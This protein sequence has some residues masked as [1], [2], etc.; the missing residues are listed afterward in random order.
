MAQTSKKNAPMNLRYDPYQVFRSSKTPA[1]LYARQKW[2][3]EGETP[4]WKSDYQNMVNGLLADQMPDGSWQHGSVE[5]IRHLF[6][7]HL[8]VRS[9][10]VQIEAGLNWLLNKIELRREKIHVN[11]EDFAAVADLKGLPFI[12]SRPDMLLTGAG[13]FLA[14][15]FGRENDPTVLSSYQWLS[16]QGVK[17]NGHWFDRASFHNIFRAMVVHPVFAKDRATGL[18]VEHLA[19]FQAKRGDWGKELPFY[20]TLNAL[21]HLNFSQAQPQ[22]EKAFERLFETQN[23]DGSWGRI[24]PEW[25]TFLAI[26][27]LKNKELI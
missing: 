23:S 1:G 2:I 20:Q 11:D 18:A 21:A 27:A 8:T 12:P 17:S 14:S 7:L 25:N 5:T 9:S 10:S 22:L 24:Q 16:D 15:I 19:N 4:H 3:E 6:G 26:H 13:L